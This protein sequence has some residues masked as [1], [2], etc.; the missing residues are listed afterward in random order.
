[1]F[2]MFDA[3]RFVPIQIVSTVMEQSGMLSH[4]VILCTDVAQLLRRSERFAVN[5][6]NLPLR[7]RT[8]RR[9]GPHSRRVRRVQRTVQSNCVLCQQTVAFSYWRSLPWGWNTL[10]AGFLTKLLMECHGMWSNFWF[11]WNHLA[12]SHLW[13][14]STFWPDAWA[15]YT[16]CGQMR[17]TWF[18]IL[19]F[20][21]L[22]QWHNK[23]C[24]GSLCHWK[25]ERSFLM[26]AWVQNV[27]GQSD[28]RLEASARRVFKQC[29]M[30]TA[31]RQLSV[32]VCWCLE[33][34]KAGDLVPPVKNTEK[35]WASVLWSIFI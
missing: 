19:P 24:G 23:M 1:M 34:E 2:G 21:A 4:D 33:F 31:E 30:L 32:K 28:V 11:L 22:M 6:S 8:G 3:A 26:A 13:E 12:I 9:A 10:L 18:Q 15:R 20:A 17:G 29:R 7:V 25:N 5:G 16:R 14:S 27:Q 35:D